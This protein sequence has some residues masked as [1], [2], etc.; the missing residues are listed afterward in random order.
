MPPDLAGWHRFAPE[1]SDGSVATRCAGAMK[2]KTK[3]I[4]GVI[5]LKKNTWKNILLQISEGGRKGCRS[6]A[7]HPTAFKP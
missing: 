1:R 7:K 4:R 6:P 3:K 2:K 5:I